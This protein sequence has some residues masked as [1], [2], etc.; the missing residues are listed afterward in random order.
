MPW[1]ILRGVA[2]SLRAK[3]VVPGA[4]AITQWTYTTTS[5]LGTT[6]AKPSATVSSPAYSAAR[7][8][9]M[10]ARG[11]A[12]SARTLS[13]SSIP[14]PPLLSVLRLHRHQPATEPRTRKHAEPMQRRSKPH[15]AK[16]TP[17]STSSSAASLTKKNTRSARSWS[18]TH[19][20]P[21]TPPSLLRRELQRALRAPSAWPWRITSNLTPTT[22]WVFARQ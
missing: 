14:P 12:P 9:I 19:D 15:S 20:S 8:V 1:T 6:K 7:R 13:N 5:V 4:E 2:L 18:K 17:L 10:L 16:S 21:S 3:S 22:P 11:P